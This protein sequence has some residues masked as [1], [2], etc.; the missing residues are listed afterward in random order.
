MTQA[1]RKRVAGSEIDQPREKKFPALEMESLREQRRSRL[2]RSLH[3]EW[4]MVGQA[5]PAHWAW[6]GNNLGYDEQLKSNASCGNT[7]LPAAALSLRCNL[8]HTRLTQ[9]SAQP[10]EFVSQNASS[11]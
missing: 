6:C 5:R 1:G 7:A 9:P 3:F 8:T 2:A 4:N 10:K 11:I